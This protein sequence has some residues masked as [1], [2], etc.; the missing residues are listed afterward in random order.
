VRKGLR[1]KEIENRIWPRVESDERPGGDP[2]RLPEK[3]GAGGAGGIDNS[4]PKVA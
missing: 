4:Q 1:R 3:V 2:E